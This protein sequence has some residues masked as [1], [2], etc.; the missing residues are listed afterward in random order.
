[1]RFKI[2]LSF[3]LFILAS[4]LA[5][6]TDGFTKFIEF[7]GSKLTFEEVIAGFEKR[8]DIRVQYDAQLVSPN[9]KYDIN[10]INVKAKTAFSDFLAHNGLTYSLQGNQAILKKQIV[11]VVKPMSVISGRV[12]VKQSGEFLGNA[13]ISIN[14]RKQVVYT[15]DAG[16]FSGFLNLDTNYIE[17][18]YPGMFAVFDTLSGDRNYFVNYSLEFM[19]ESLPE[20]NVK[21][22]TPSGEYVPQLGRSDQHFISKSRIKRLPHLLGEPDIIRVMSLYPGVVGGSEGM[23]GMYIRGGASDQNLVLLDDVPVFNSYHL[24]GIFSIFNDDAIKSA[25]LL[26]GSFPAKYGGRLSSVVNV[27]SK[28]GNAYRIKG[29]VSF[30]LLAS[31]IFLEGPLIKNRTTFTIAYR[32][33]YLD[34]MAKP[35]TGLLL[36][37]DSIQNNVYYFWDF[38]A[39]ITHRFNSK[40]RITASF[41]TGRDVGGID[42]KINAQNTE[43]NAT[44][45]RKQLS[46]WGN[47]LGS[48]KWNYYLGKR[49]GLLIKAHITAY[50]YSFNQ[51]YQLKKKF[52]SSSQLDLDDRTEYKL[53]NGIQDREVS[54][55]LQH[56]AGEK[57]SWNLGGGI[58]QHKFIPGN[59]TFSSVISGN[60]TE[61]FFNDPTVTTPEYFGFGELN[62][63]VMDHVY[64]DMGLRISSYQV[65]KTFYYILPEPRI[66]LRYQLNDFSWFRAGVMRTR[67]FFHLLNNLTLGL[68]SDIW[69]PSVVRFKPSL[70]DQFSIGYSYRKKEYQITTEVF[71]K[72]LKN[73]L[74]YKDNAG[75]VT[76]GNNWEDAVTDGSGEAYGWE[77]MTEK[78]RGRFTGW[79]S[80]SLMWNWRQFH[81]LNQGNKFP[82]RYD[83]RNN[84]YIAGVYRVKKNFDFSFSWTYNSGFAITT[85][86]AKYLS[87]TPQDPYREIYIFGDRNN[88]RTRDNHRLDIAFN[89]EKAL[90]NGSRIWSIGVFNVYNRRN[91]FYVNLGYSA[92]GERVLYQVSLLPILPNVSYKLNF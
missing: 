20:A 40:S 41:Y 8:M 15:S 86:I 51:S 33:S 16:Y 30:G 68:P 69:V 22:I 64:L 71:Y 76:S 4:G 91:P 81:E 49:T 44:E 56:K 55:S 7:K 46:S 25:T 21:V 32:R 60:E 34:F 42:E 5:G 29:S 18:N 53:Q 10:Y 48:I 13:E 65:L 50:D 77:I 57:L 63:I 72:K 3:L 19:S 92:S 70:C 74:E 73:I 61:Y 35:V 62:A 78:T 54:A 87:P 58:C 24:Y 88:T 52:K 17:I 1:M 89:F 84:I 36:N 85:P 66:S 67:Q 6:Q 83:R 90:K 26:K 38:N 39:R 75:Y 2:I 82:S 31:K 12:V 80:Y 23:L 27:Q 43:F 47:V 37:N 45:R 11:P 9:K 14:H 79:L 28:E 59:R